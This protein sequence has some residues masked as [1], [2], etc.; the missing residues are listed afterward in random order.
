MWRI[1]SVLLCLF[2]LQ[3]TANTLKDPTMPGD[4]REHRSQKAGSG[5]SK[6]TSIITSAD[7]NFAVIGNRVLSVGDTVGSARITAIRSDYVALSDGKTL[8]LFQ[9]ITER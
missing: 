4:F 5:S 9:A 6:L 7:G 1:I 8:R 2:A 3:A